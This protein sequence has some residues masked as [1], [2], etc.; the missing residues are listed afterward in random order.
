MKYKILV[1]NVVGYCNDKILA[2]FMN[3]KL[4]IWQRI[5]YWIWI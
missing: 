4:T 3:R 5:Y 1:G 2:K